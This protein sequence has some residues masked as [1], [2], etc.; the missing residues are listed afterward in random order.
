M[1]EWADRGRW[2]EGGRMRAMVRMV[3]IDGYI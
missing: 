3:D 1:E 2:E